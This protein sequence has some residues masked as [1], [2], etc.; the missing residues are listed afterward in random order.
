MPKIRAWNIC[1]SGV[2][3]FTLHGRVSARPIDGWRK[4]GMR[5]RESYGYAK[6]SILQE[7]TKKDRRNDRIRLGVRTATDARPCALRLLRDQT[8][9]RILDDVSEW[10]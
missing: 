3:N 1:C 5:T 8:S 6:D 9:L 7:R 4:E 10:H 2:Q